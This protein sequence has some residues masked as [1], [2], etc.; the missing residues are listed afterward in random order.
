[1][2]RRTAILVPTPPEIEPFR[3]RQ[4]DTAGIVLTGVGPYRCATATTEAILG[5]KYDLLVLAGIAGAYP[6]RGLSAGDVILAE[7]ERSADLGSFADGTFSAK[8]GRTYRCPHIPEEMPW[9]RVRSNSAGAAAA[10]YIER[11]EAEIE[12][13]EG[14]AFFHAC[15]R[16]GMPFVE[17]RAISNIVG[18]PFGAWRIQQAT[19]ALADALDRL[20]TILNEK[21]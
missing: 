14:A 4:P 7:S 1:M 11:T 3:T 5:G 15:L 17:L 18:E 8:F 13:M 16:H 20:L 12:N 10:P 19:E 6:G 21:A 2:K 9:P